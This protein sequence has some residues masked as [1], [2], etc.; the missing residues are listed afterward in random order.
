M[1]DFKQNFE[2]SSHILNVKTMGWGV[3]DKGK[4]H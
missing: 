3:Y 1:T 4:R 2:Y